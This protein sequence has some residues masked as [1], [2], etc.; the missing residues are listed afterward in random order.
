MTDATTIDHIVQPEE[1]DGTIRVALLV[2]YCGTSFHGSQFQ[3]ELP[4]IQGA[5]QDA[6]KRLNLETSAVTFAGRTDTGVHAVGQVAHFDVP[7]DGLRQVPDLVLALN[8]VLPATVAVRASRLDVGRPFHSRRE[9]V[10]KWYR[11]KIYNS[12]HRSAWASQM[13]AAHY[14]YR[15]DETLMNQAA[16]LILGEHEFTSFKDSGSV[17]TSDICCIQHAKVVRDGDFIILDVAA[18]R[19]L[20]KM[21]RNIVGQLMLIGNANNPHPP[22]AILKVLAERDRRKAARSA[23]PEGLT[24]MAVQYKSP[25]NFFEKDVYVQQF[26]NIL[27]S[28]ESLQNENLFRKAS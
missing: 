2:E 23:S 18:N 22:E 27:K 5:L 17:V 7:E 10:A 15:L 26:K 12:S 3:P 21:V 25:F 24:L 8:A 1:N 16:Q 14:H 9:A 19:F 6:L 20:Y 13:P 11:Y 28:M 4:T